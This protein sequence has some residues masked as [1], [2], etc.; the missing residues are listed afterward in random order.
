MNEER[1]MQY[2]ELARSL[3]YDVTDPKS[4]R[5]LITAVKYC[6][7]RFTDRKLTD[8][9]ICEQLGISFDLLVDLKHT[10]AVRIATQ[11][12]LAYFLEDEARNDI[13][14]QLF[15]TYQ[16]YMPKALLNIAKMAAG[17]VIGKG[18]DEDG[19]EYDIHAA[20]RDQVAAATLLMNNPLAT[21]WLQNTFIGESTNV[22]EAAH[23]SMQ[24]KL[25]SQAKVL[26]L[27]EP[28]EGEVKVEHT[29]STDM[30]S[31][32]AQPQSSS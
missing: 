8:R 28:I 12:V 15:Q 22:D 24:Q 29:A 1:R 27:D 26:N 5:N 32:P 16:D 13:R 17:E 10:D 14:A 11:L 21:A 30:A 23:I 6:D 20:A 4:V 25:L 2:V 7:L 31:L 18:I 9:Q 3:G 19:S